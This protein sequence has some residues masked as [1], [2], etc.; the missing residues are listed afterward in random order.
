MANLKLN[1][2]CMDCNNHIV[3][4]PDSDMLSGIMY[5]IQFWQS[6]GKC[7]VL[8]QAQEAS[9]TPTPIPIA[10]KQKRKARK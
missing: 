4:P 1:V 2:Q 3:F 8:K 10:K 5:I 7:S 9:K 6:H